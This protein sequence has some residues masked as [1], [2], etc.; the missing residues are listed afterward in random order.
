MVLDNVGHLDRVSAE[1]CVGAWHV[2]YDTFDAELV[3]N[4]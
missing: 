3:L 2:R 4:G 1:T